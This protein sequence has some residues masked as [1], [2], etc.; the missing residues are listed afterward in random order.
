MIL[1]AANAVWLPDNATILYLAEAV[2]PRQLFFLKYIRPS[3]GRFPSDHEVPHFPRH[4]LAPRHDLRLRAQ[5]G[6]LR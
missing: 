6:S 4:R 3:T 2:K 5:A 1:N